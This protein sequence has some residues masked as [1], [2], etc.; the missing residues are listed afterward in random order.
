MDIYIALGLGLLGTF[1]GS[2][3]GAQVWR[4]R[5]RQ[6]AEDKQHGEKVNAKE[7]RRLERLVRPVSRDRSECLHC[8]HVL[9]WYDLIP[10]VSW[11]SLGGKCRY[12]RHAIGTTELAV[13]IGLG[14]VFAVS[15]LCWPLPLE[16]HLA[17]IQF[18]LWL[19]ACT[20][21]TI[22]FVYDARWY[23]LPFVINSSLIAM[24]AVYALTHLWQDGFTSAA[25]LSLLGALLVLAG[26]YY[27][28]SLF[29][30]VGL[31]DS[32]LGVGLALLLGTWQLALLAL[33][34]ANLFG[35]LALLPLAC[36]GRLR[37]SMHIPFGPFLI[38]GTVV[39]VI[40]GGQL[41]ELF[42]QLSNASFMS[43]M[44]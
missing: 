3:A 31:G 37:R 27:I 17:W 12:C 34:L 19:A 40:W 36:S 32:I 6:L 39:A 16:T 28:F 21:M 1:L 23:L 42:L 4:L 25:M 10:L 13:E 33:F 22:L 41:I 2:F 35:C 38:L 14:L 5:A 18:A 9:A 24:G 30:W 20:L 44:V 43:L 7:L 8:H 26:L 29:G 11:L 15:Y